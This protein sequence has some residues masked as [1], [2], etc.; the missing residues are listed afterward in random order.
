[1]FAWFLNFDWSNIIACLNGKIYKKET[2]DNYTKIL[3]LRVNVSYKVVSYYVITITFRINEKFKYWIFLCHSV[4][5]T[6]SRRRIRRT[7][8]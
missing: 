7:G 1:M 8:N 2:W 6:F 5:K 3:K 4:V